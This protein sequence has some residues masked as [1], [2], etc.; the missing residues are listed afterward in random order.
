VFE[1]SVES[2]VGSK[3]PF[4]MEK[5]HHFKSRASSGATQG[6]EEEEMNERESKEGM[7]DRWRDERR[8]RSREGIQRGKGWVERG[9]KRR[10]RK[11]VREAGREGIW[12][13]LVRG[14]ECEDRKGLEWKRGVEGEEIG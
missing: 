6:I 3:F 4:S 7:E 9:E 5:V 11:G 14:R 1:L 10:E 12:K 13:W 8:R 2:R